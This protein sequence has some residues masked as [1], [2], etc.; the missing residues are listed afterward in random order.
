MPE[1]KELRNYIENIKQRYNQYQQQQQ[2]N[3]YREKEIIILK[4]NLKNMK[5]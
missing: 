5:K 4:N 2:L 3:I 1:N